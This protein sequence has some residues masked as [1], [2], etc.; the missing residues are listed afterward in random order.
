[1]SGKRDS[2]RELG[3]KKKGNHPPAN[4]SRGGGWLNNNPKGKGKKASICE[5]HNKKKNPPL[6]VRRGNGCLFLFFFGTPL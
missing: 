1:M 6:R 2:K 3:K 4:G 5:A